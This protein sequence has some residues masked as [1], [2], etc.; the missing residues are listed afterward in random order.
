MAF[1]RSYQ[2][3][4]PKENRAVA[5]CPGPNLIYFGEIYSFEEMVRHI[6]G[7]LDL[8]DKVKRPHI[9][10]KEL[11]LYIDYLQKDLQ[12]H[13]A[14]LNDKKRKYLN[15]FKCQLQEGIN[16]YKQL[17]GQ[18]SDPLLQCIDDLMVSENKLNSLII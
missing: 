16:Y 15:N 17:F 2:I 10:I 5:I 8:L 9:F 18:L 12:N 1:L 14:D 6:Y 3:S 11:D 13:L 4:K 7:K